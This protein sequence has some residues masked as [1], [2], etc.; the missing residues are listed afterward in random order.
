[1]VEKNNQTENKIHSE[2]VKEGITQAR[3]RRKKWGRPTVAEV[4][5]DSNIAARAAEMRDFGLSWS[6]IASNLG[7]GR[8][9][10]RR[11]VITC[12]KDKNVWTREDQNPS[13]PKAHPFETDKLEKGLSKNSMEESTQKGAK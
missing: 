9:T 12:Q 8:T 7:V 6:Q 4:K 2:R 13:V 1:M 3:A 11:L 5:G 10:A